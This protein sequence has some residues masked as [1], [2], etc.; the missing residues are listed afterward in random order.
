[1]RWGR[2][3][4]PRMSGT[5]RRRRQT[6]SVFFGIAIGL[7][8]CYKGFHC[9]AGAAG[10]GRAATESFVASFLAIIALN[11]V[12]AKVLDTIGEIYV[13]KGLSSAFA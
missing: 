8:A 11:L 4:D 13:Y 12:L 6:E 2:A 3:S 10:V 7:I 5:A 9:E 1:L